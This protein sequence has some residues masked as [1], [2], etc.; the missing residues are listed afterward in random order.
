MKI[1]HT[2][3]FH[4]GKT[5]YE[6]SLVCQQRK[7]LNDICGILSESDYAALIIAGDI[8][9]RSIPPA[10]SVALLDSFLC[11]VRRTSPKTSIFIIPGNHD[12][13]ERLSFG[14]RIF[15]EEKIFIKADTEKLSDGIIITHNDENIQIFLMP[16][17]HLGSII[18]RGGEAEKPLTTQYDMAKA[19]SSILRNAVSLDMPSVL[20][21]HL[22]TLSGKSSLEERSFI[23]T[24]EQV[25]PE[26]FNFFSYTALGHLHKYQ[27]ITDKMFYS[28]APLAY[29]FDEC[30]D[31][32]Y[33]LSVDINC[34]K[35]GFPVD[36]KPIPI[37]P[38]RRLRRLCGNFNEF[39]SGNKFDDYAQDFLEI[40]LEGNDVVTAPMGLLKNK[41]PYLLSVRQKAVEEF[42]DS[43][44]AGG[45]KIFEKNIEDP[46]VILKNFLQFESEINSPAD[47]AKLKLFKDLSGELNYET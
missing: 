40:T 10:E 41:F 36:V 22:F 5:L 44:T 39:Y 13:A 38:F 27:R 29:S 28:G 11:D 12:S 24:A 7:M 43:E 34:R 6:T 18:K 2:A 23:G 1:L 46:A 21:A 42:L 19:A 17:L 26:F 15:K 37:E 45:I 8:F 25:P 3:D 16:F 30:G 9:D 4:L 31:K 35:K 47:E 33:V 20:A 32:K 14:S